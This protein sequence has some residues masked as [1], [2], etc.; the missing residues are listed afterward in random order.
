[1]GNLFSGFRPQCSESKKSDR[2]KTIN[3]IKKNAMRSYIK[4]TY[5]SNNWRNWFVGGKTRTLSLK[6]NRTRRLY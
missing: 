3:E 6:R 1:M 5:G 4:S 2:E